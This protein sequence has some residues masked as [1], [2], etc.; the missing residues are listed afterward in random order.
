M[1]I[2]K[3][4]MCHYS[5][6]TERREYIENHIKN[7]NIDLEWILFYDKED[8]DWDSLD[9]I[10]PNILNIMNE[11]GRKLSKPEISLLLKHLEVFRDVIKNNYSNVIV[12]EDDI[13]LDNDF[14]SKLDTYITQLPIDY[15][16]FWIGSCCNLHTNTIPNKYVYD[17][18]SS[19]CT[20]AYLISK[21]GCEKMLECL[22]DLNHPIDWF[23]NYVI[24][25]KKLKNYWA[26]PDLAQQN[27]VFNTTIQHNK[28][29]II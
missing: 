25:T 7:F 1:E 15:D 19:R 10:Y 12:F 18:N 17:A 24:R 9:K 16:I 11:F 21:K 6:L 4:Y 27:I 29:E 28:N 26:E 20:H 14:N 13:I 2:N 22:N 23:F 8:I 3:Y 5:K